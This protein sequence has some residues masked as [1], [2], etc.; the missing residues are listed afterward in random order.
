MRPRFGF[1]PLLLAFLAALAG[2]A[3]SGQKAADGGTPV[4][5]ASASSSGAG[6]LAMTSQKAGAGAATAN[7]LPPPDAP[8]AY[9]QQQ[10]EYRIGPLDTLE[11]TVFQVPDLT[12]PLQVD[13]GGQVSLPL[14]GIMTAS[15]K[16]AQEL[17]AEIA[18]ALGA[19][20]L[21]S[22]QVTIV[23]KD[24]PRQKV[25]V[26]GAV[27]TPG[28]FPISG[29]TTLLQAVALSQG[30]SETS[31]PT[32][33]LIFRTVNNQRMAARFNLK[34]IRSGSAPDPEIYGGDIVV[35]GESAA[36]VRLRDL[37]SVVPVLGI[38]NPLI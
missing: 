25:T 17:A 14:I 15:G 28:I 9:V 1:R 21:Q 38:F 18:A 20:Y 24:S 8:G 37:R 35:V 10:S 7:A 16:T 29:K 11:L 32:E 26:E 33:V 12:R 36:R 27:K 5:A 23:V 30:T 31:D 22:P 34:M 4:P 2:C 19:K 3:T 13:A 6:A